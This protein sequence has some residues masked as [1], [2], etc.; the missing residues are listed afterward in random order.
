[1]V[2]RFLL[3]GA[4]EGAQFGVLLKQVLHLLGILA[5]GAAQ[6]E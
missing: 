6:V 5:E 1:M 4:T 3:V 2:F